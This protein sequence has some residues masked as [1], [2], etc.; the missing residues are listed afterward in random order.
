MKKIAALSVA[1]AALVLFVY[2]YEIE[3]G[4]KREEAK[5]LEESLFR[6]KRDGISWVRI[7]RPDKDPITLQKEGAEWTLEEPIE[8]SADG[9][10]VDSFLRDL[11]QATRDRTLESVENAEKYGLEQPRMTIQYWRPR[12]KNTSFGRRRL[13]REQALRPD[14]GCSRGFSDFR[15]SLH[16]CR[17]RADGLAEQE[18][19]DF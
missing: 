14:P 7:Q 13:H 17:Q 19:S 1:L 6:A 2:F 18:G 11:E 16:Q 3:G 15:C 5:E 8:T 9:T 4:Q 12:R 10:S